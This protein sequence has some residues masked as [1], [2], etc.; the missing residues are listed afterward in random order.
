[1]LVVN[2]TCAAKSKNG[3]KTEVVVS[4]AEGQNAELRDIYDVTATHLVGQVFRFRRCTVFQF[5]EFTEW[6]L[7]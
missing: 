4:A 3:I 1:M 6:C 7:F 2:D 5:I